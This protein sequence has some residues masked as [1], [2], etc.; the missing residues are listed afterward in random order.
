MKAKLRPFSLI[1]LVL[2]LAFLAAP[3][4][5]QTAFLQDLD[6][7]PLPS[8]LVEDEAAGLSFDKP[9]GR[10]VEAE[11]SGAL[12]QGEVRDFYARTLPQLGWT[13]EG[14][15]RFLRAGESLS[16]SYSEAGGSLTVHYTLQPE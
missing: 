2:L 15:D 9:S 7:V 5:A 12:P 3:A 8:G 1:R 6:D 13:A 14:G 10:I 16:L 11:A 4:W